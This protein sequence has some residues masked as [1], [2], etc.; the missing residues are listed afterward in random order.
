MSIK[1]DENKQTVE[2]LEKHLKEIEL[3]QENGAKYF[4]I[5]DLDAALKKIVDKE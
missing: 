4:T 2:K 5:D 1:I 3:E